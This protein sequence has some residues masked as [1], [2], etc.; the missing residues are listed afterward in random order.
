MP[1]IGF[2]HSATFDAVAH[3]MIAFRSGLR[4]TGF[5]EGPNLAIEYRFAEGHYDRLPEL[6]ADLVRHQVAVIAA[7]GG[8]PPSLAVKAATATIPIVFISST[9]PVKL[10][11]VASFNKPGGNAT[12]VS[13]LTSLMAAKRLELMRELVPKDAIIAALV[14]PSS[15][16][17]ETQSKD[18][19]EA[20]QSIGQRLIMLSASTD[21]DIDAAFATLVQQRAAALVIDTD[22]FFY[23]RR[24]QFVALEARYRIPAIYAQREFIAAGGLIS[25]G[26]SIA[27]AN[28]QLGVYAGQILKG[29]RPSDPPVLQPT[30]FELVINLKT[31]KA[32]GVTV[33][34]AMQLLADEVID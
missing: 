19:R 33:S 6:A 5:I 16:S 31:A 8:D 11:L 24:D 17:A 4:E 23:V 26:A 18:L 12:G 27:D 1:V 15:P 28:R 29:A 7:S 20:A 3:L 22:A 2:L 21:S 25:Y 9:D 30:K 10:G 34:N 13:V 14:N 32:L